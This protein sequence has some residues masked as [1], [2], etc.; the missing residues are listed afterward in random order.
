MLELRSN[1]PKEF[2]TWQFTI[3]DGECDSIR[4]KC[5][6]T[7]LIKMK[8]KLY[9]ML[10]KRGCKHI[11][12]TRRNGKLSRCKRIWSVYGTLD[13]PKS[14]S[15]DY[16]GMPFT[17]NERKSNTNKSKKNRRKPLFFRKPS[18]FMSLISKERQFI[19]LSLMR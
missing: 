2:K 13:L 5:Q 16:V 3:K 8:S 7:L 1:E 10:C 17:N 9:K 4:I 14:A 18:V 15:T 6:N 12:S 19:L 11:L